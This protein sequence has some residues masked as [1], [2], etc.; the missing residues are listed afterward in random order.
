MALFVVKKSQAK[1]GG[2]QVPRAMSHHY[3]ALILVKKSPF[4]S[5]VVVWERPHTKI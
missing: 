1:N 2:K 5:E 3:C 4:H